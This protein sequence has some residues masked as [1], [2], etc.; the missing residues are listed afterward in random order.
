MLHTSLGPTLEEGFAEADRPILE[1]VER[2]FALLPTGMELPLG[3]FEP[4]SSVGSIAFLLNRIDLNFP[5]LRCKE[6]SINE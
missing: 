4:A 5:A 1:R 6:V 2:F 3:V